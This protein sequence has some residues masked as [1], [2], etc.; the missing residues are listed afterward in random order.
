MRRFTAIMNKMETLPLTTVWQVASIMEARGKQELWLQKRPETLTALRQQAVIH[1]VESSNRI[2]GVTIQAE[3]LRPLLLENAR[4]R[5]RSEEELSG[6]RKALDWI[7]TKSTREPLTPRVV[8]HLHKLAQGGH[9]GDAGMWKAQ[10]NEIIELLPN[11]ERRIRFTPTPARAVPTAM[12]NLC[13]DYGVI[14]GGD[15]AIIPVALAAFVFE[16]LCVHPFR[17]GNGRVSRL[18]TTLLLERHGFSLC[19]YVSL[20]RLI[21]E[22]KDEYYS[23]LERCSRGWHEGTNELVPWLNYL[24]GVIRRSYEELARQVESAEDTGKSE[25]VR[26]AVRRQHVAFTLADIQAACPSASVQLVKKVLAQLKE[27]GAIS[28]TGKGRG[29]R[30]RVVE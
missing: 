5:D 18:L 10:D 1:S 16:F 15:A 14:A 13:A 2:E 26:K 29:A 17:D 19:R 11:G 23:V 28:L 7:F 30:W 22:S 9:S 21:E 3:R 24:L 12:K 20:E 8:L 25:L 6:Y 27:D 4:P